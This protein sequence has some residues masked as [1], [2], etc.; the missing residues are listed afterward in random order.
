[1]KPLDYIGRNHTSETSRKS[2]NTRKTRLP[3]P[4]IGG[5]GK[6][7][8]EVAMD[9]TSPRRPVNLLEL[10]RRV[11]GIEWDWY[12]GDKQLLNIEGRWQLMPEP[13]DLAGG[14]FWDWYLWNRRQWFD[15]KSVAVTRLL[16]AWFE[17]QRKREAGA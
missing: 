7:M 4:L 3:P 1:M 14:A 8:G 6:S 11:T 2:S 17:F 9:E 12:H 10:C 16:C 13:N 15:Q 5:G